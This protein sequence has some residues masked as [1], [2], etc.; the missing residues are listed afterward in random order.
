MGDWFE[1]ERHVEKAHEYYELGRWDDAETELRSAL[2]L[3]PY[4]GE[5]YFNLGLTLE[6]AGRFG[7]AA[8]AFESCYEL[9]NQES[10]TAVFVAT[11]LIRAG[12][13]E[14]ALPWLEKASSDAENADVFVQQIH[15]LTD[16]ERHEDAETAFYLAL[17]RHP[18]HAEL[19]TA[20]ADSLLDRSLHD[21]AVWCLRQAA[22]LDPEL[23]RVEARLAEAFA[24]TGRQER[25]RQLYL[26][27]LRRDPG[28]IDTLL[29]MGD[30]LI[31]MNR[32]DE[33]T[34]KFRRVLELEPDNPDAHVALAQ[35][36]RDAGD[37]DAAVTAYDVALRLDPDD[38]RTRDAL[39]EVLLDRGAPVDCD[40]AAVLLIER[41]NRIIDAKP[42]NA[43]RVR[44]DEILSV[45]R[46]LLDARRPAVAVRL[47]E[48]EVAGETDD[49]PRKICIERRHLLAV[50][51]LESGL[52]DRGVAESRRTLRLDPRHTQA[53]HNIAVAHLRNAE[54]V[55]ARSWVRKALAIKPDDPDLRRLRSA[56]NI[57]AAWLITRSTWRFAVQSAR[58]A[59]ALITRPTRSLPS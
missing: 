57:R 51:L 48:S 55:R 47:L 20:M 6:A 16:L 33:A 22:R 7:E 44:H 24:A 28:D 46:L 58:V 32:L 26:R 54:W 34:D 15:A 13:P 52:I 12:Q 17:E 50:A 1:A 53:M 38:L 40:R 14:Q 45:A 8:R 39:A 56:L 35:V 42:D 18:D 29:D 41:A 37:L 4:Q 5:W 2:S 43:D 23:P 49:L 21:K 9:Q 25:A 59:K 19:Y 3:N 30:L 31:E 11:N 10:A 27:E 36:A